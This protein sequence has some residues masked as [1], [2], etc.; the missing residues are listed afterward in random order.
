MGGGIGFGFREGKRRRYDALS[1]KKVLRSVTDTTLN[2]RVCLEIPIAK[3]INP[4][5]LVAYII[6]YNRK[7]VIY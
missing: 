4:V 3:R 2:I 6:S 7:N 1:S 5:V